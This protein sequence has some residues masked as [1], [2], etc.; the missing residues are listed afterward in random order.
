MNIQMNQKIE[1]LLGVQYVEPI[2]VQKQLSH[3]AHQTPNLINPEFQFPQFKVL[4][5]VFFLI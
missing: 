2:F 5:S 1:K 4:Q 3:S